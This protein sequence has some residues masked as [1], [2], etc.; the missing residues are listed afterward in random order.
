[1]A[2]LGHQAERL[3][4]ALLRKHLQGNRRQQ[5]L[6]Q[7]RQQLL[8]QPTD[9]P[10]PGRCHLQQIEGQIAGIGAPLGR[11]LPAP[12]LQLAEFHKAA[13]GGQGLKAGLHP[14][15]LEAVEHHI[16]TAPAGG[17]QH[18]GAEGGAARIKHRLH[19]LLQQGRLFGCTG[20][21]EDPGAATARHLQGGL[22]HPARRGMDQHGFPRLHL[23]QGLQPVDRREKGG[24]QAGPLLRAKGRWQ[25]HAQLRAAHHM[26]GQA[27]H[28]QGGQHPLPQ[29]LVRH[30]GAHRHHPA[31]R[32][33]PEGQAGPLLGPELCGA[34][35][36]QP[37]GI[38]HIAEIEA[39]G[40]HGDLQLPR[41]QPRRALGPLHQGIQAAGAGAHPTAALRPEGLQPQGAD[42]APAPGQGRLALRRRPE[43]RPIGR[44][45]LLRRIVGQLQPR[46]GQMG[47]L[48]RR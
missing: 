11:L 24:T 12:D 1:M 23:R 18:F 41:L 14:G 26:A 43:Q 44:A 28:R 6:L 5:A 37:Q 7:I 4:A 19:P 2:G 45:G 40:L 32:L 47:L 42:L 21:G 35:G 27:A 22:A 9:Q 48:Q 8:K 20:G 33:P 31:H 13:A 3:R 30:L 17:R 36:Q 10:W 29:Q 39:R 16:H 34:G 46:P 15:P 38:E 25:G